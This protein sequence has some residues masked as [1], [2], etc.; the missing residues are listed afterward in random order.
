M[1]AAGSSHAD[2]LDQFAEFE[3]YLD[4]YVQPVDLYYLEDE[5]LARQLVELDVKG[6]G[7]LLSRGEFERL[8][9]DETQRAAKIRNTSTKPLAHTGV[10]AS[11]KDFPLLVE[12]AQREELVL[13]GRLA[14]IVF[15]R[16]RNRK[17]QEVSAYIDLGHRLKTDS[18]EEYFARRKL[19]QPRP[20]DLSFYN[21]DTGLCSSN[22][23]TNF[24]VIA[25]SEKGLQFK[26]KRDRKLINV[27]PDAPPG[28]SSF[29]KVIED[30]QYTQVVLYDHVTRRK[31]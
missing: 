26:C 30:P 16:T 22:A 17:G 7:D 14:T 6:P 29:R 4:S 2:S 18:F 15:I 9:N 28:H 11:Y 24:Q 25:D 13:S 23:T 12:L 1:A 19:F 31:A 8:K 21:A 3:D 27:S 20:S 10:Q 5:E